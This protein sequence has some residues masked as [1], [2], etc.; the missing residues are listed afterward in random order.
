MPYSSS[1]R[2]QPWQGKGYR[3]GIAGKRILVLGESHYHSCDTPGDSCNGLSPEDQDARHLRLT[4]S[5]VKYW[6]DNPHSTPL[7][8]AV[9]KLFEM[10]KSEF[11]ERVAFYNY[12]QTFSSAARVRPSSEAWS[13]DIAVASFQEVLDA[14]EPDR[15]L[16]LGKDLWCSL[17]SDDR[18]L[19]CRPR[20]EEN[21]PLLEK[22][23]NRNP[24]DGVGYW[25]GCR[26]G[27]FALAMPI[28]HPAS[29]GFR[30]EEWRPEVQKWISFP[31]LQGSMAK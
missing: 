19:A 24:V 30:A 20:A 6:K 5:E 21:L 29:W 17:P 10:T 7:S 16:V 14:L 23:G 2:F 8:T 26:S 1:V 31:N 25:Y 9:P 22:I 18:L 11:W 15:I 4:M 12:V 28:F 13:D 27:S 3:D